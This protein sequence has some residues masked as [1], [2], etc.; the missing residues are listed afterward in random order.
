M[1]VI[2]DIIQRSE[3]WFIEKNGKPSSSN[4]DK[5]LTSTGKKSSQRK[6]YLYSLADSVCRGVVEEGYTN[7]AM[8]EG[9]A[10]E[11]ESRRLFEFLHGPVQEVGMVYKDK[12]KRFLCSPDG[13]LINEPMGLELKNPLGKTHIQYLEEGKLPTKYFCQV[14]G[15]MYVTGYESWYFMSYVPGYESFILEVKRDNDWCELLGEALDKFCTELDDL[16]KRR[17]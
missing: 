10:R 2:S 14:H 3:E 8:E 4:F 1:I 12:Y 9:V 11:S 15:S 16:V 17:G 7:E 13:L 5:I 6:S